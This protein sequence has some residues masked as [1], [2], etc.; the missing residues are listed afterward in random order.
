MTKH[1]SSDGGSEDRV[2]K[3]EVEHEKEEKIESREG[4]GKM[5]ADEKQ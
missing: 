4:D 5:S 3:V 1:K 2:G